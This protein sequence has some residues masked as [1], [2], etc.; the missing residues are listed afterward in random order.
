MGYLVLARSFGETALGMHNTDY[1]PI[2]TE[3]PN[4]SDRLFV[5]GNGTSTT[6]RNDALIILKNGTSYFN[7]VL[8]PAIDN[9]HSLGS[10]SNR[11]TAVYATNGT[12]QTSDA[13]YKT[14]I[15]TIDNPLEKITR[16]NGVRYTWNSDEYPEMN[17]DDAVH[18]GVLAQE[19][20]EVLPE[21]VYTDE[22]GYKSV[23]YEKLAPV[24]IEAVKEQQ[25]EIESQQGEIEQYIDKINEQ[26]NRIALLTDK[27]EEL[28]LRIA[29]IESMLGL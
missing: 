12:I 21:L 2:D 5:I 25:G 14:N 15:E 22:N 1:T 13:R 18:L 10:S 29:A 26:E 9:T 4:N 8:N 20:E 19:V 7:G 17:F 24:L 11:W 16:I 6:E 27:N 3:N 28:M 23:S